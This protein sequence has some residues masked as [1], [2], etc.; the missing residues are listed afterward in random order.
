MTSNLPEFQAILKRL[1]K[2][3]KENS[4]LKRTALAVLV[5]SGVVLLMGQA[6]P[7]PR[8]RT[9]EAERFVVKDGTGRTWASLGLKENAPALILYDVN[10]KERLGLDV[11]HFEETPEGASAPERLGG[12]GLWLT[13]ENGEPRA[14]L[15]VD[16]GEPSLWLHNLNGTFGATLYVEAEG[17]KLKLYDPS[18]DNKVIWSAP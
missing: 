5:V 6:R 16:S 2:L 8:T 1:E 18:K 10:G 15:T 17:P 12:P 11:T 4:R 14:G 13:N 7:R 9:V 3:E